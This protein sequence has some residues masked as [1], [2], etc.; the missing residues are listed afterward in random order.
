MDQPLTFSPIFKERV[1][2]GR[3]L[4]T[5]YEKALPEN[6]LIGE[7]WEI[8]D[9][10]EA[11]SVVS[12]GPHQGIPL[13]ALMEDYRHEIL[14][15]LADRHDHFPLLVKILDAREKLS[16]Q[17]HPPQKLAAELQGEPKTE[18]WYVADAE[19]HASVYAG[20]KQGVTKDQFSY[21]CQD[22]TVADCFHEISVKRGDCL[23]LESGRVHALGGGNLIFEIQQNSDT[24]Y[25][26]FDWT[27][28][29]STGNP[30]TSIS[31]SRFRRLIS[32]ILSQLWKG[33]RWFYRNPVS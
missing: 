25:R 19:P 9:R 2:G 28:W 15:C 13:R 18:M 16:L 23:F 1:W 14:G 21:Q 12:K 4:A 29:V 31:A 32:M 10:P 27:G 24:T 6:A 17:V 7:S 11:V 5:V 26:V 33:P 3:R 20:L 30:E 22:G 8:T